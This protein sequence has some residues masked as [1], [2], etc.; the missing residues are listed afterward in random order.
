MC[1]WTHTC[2]VLSTPCGEDTHHTCVGRCVGR[3]QAHHGQ[4]A[5]RMHGEHCSGAA[6]PWVTPPHRNRWAVLAGDRWQ[7]R[8]APA[9]P[10]PHL[11]LILQETA[12]VGGTESS[13]A[14][15][16]QGGK[17][18]KWESFS[19]PPLLLLPSSSTP[20]STSQEQFFFRGVQIS[21]QRPPLAAI[22]GGEGG[23]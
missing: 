10:P 8:P 11:D 21:L 3:W 1:Q 6:V 14:G 17:G 15:S 13:T 4:M 5:I 9:R 7:Q 2:T 19:S 18:R 16:E 22:F 20:G 12:G 23:V